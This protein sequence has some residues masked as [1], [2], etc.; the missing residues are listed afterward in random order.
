MMSGT[1]QLLLAQQDTCRCLEGNVAKLNDDVAMIQQEISEGAIKNL[2]KPSTSKCKVP[3]ELS[4]RII[5][6][7]VF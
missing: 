4:V 7:F 6:S 2:K 3:S 5:C 1:Q